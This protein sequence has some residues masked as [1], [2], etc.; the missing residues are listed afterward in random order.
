MNTRGTN[1]LKQDAVLRAV[2]FRLGSVL[3]ATGTRRTDY[4]GG[5]GKPRVILDEGTEQ[6]SRHV[7]VVLNG[8]DELERLVPTQ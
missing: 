2:C 3:T 4:L 1:C 8:F 7:A 6:F 5:T